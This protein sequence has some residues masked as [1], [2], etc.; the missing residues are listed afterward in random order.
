MRPRQ[1]P[2]KGFIIGYRDT[3]EVFVDAMPLPLEPS[4]KVSDH[5][6]TGFC[7]GYH[8]SGPSQLAL[9]LLLNFGAK[10]N[11]ALAWYQDF[12][13]E[14]IA[15]LPDTDFEIPMSR[16]SDWLSAR[17]IFEKEFDE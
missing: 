6:P 1:L 3:L 16:V 9:A 5:S 10:K 7:W 2:L 15:N 8:G 17:R 12:K 4:L 14:V 13:R 11:E